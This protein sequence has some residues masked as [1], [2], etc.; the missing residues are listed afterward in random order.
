MPSTTIATSDHPVFKRFSRQQLVT[1]RRNI[2]YQTLVLQPTFPRAKRCKHCGRQFDSVW[3]EFQCHVCGLW[4]C[5]PCSYVLERERELQCITFMRSCVGCQPMLNKWLDPDL[6]AQFASSSW[7]VSCSKRQLSLNLSDILR[8]KECR[9]PALTVLKYL[10]RPVDPASP[11]VDT[12]TEDEWVAATSEGSVG[13]PRHGSIVSNNAEE[14]VVE[15]VQHLVQQCFEVVIPEEPISDC[16]FA[17]SNGSR[18]YPIHY[19]D[20][21]EPPDAPVIS[22]ELERQAAIARYGL[23]TRSLNTPEI[24]LICNLA[25]QELECWAA[26]I[27]IVSGDTQQFVASSPG[28][29]CGEPNKRSQT[30]CSYALTSP[31]PYMIRDASL[32]IRFRNFD[33][34][35]GPANLVFYVGFPIVDESNNTMALLCVLDKKPRKNIT[36][37]QYSVA[38]R[39]AAVVSALW[40]ELLVGMVKS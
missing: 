21:D 25:A 30:F 13:S 39:L 14:T 6:L 20:P 2:G 29:P 27:S 16:L 36:T 32:D 37:M 10:G 7:V 24:Q 18:L 33:V 17:E 4:V 9:R 5:Q 34:V 31:L 8:M 35:R 40:K 23:L 38:K 11:C 22:S 12:I 28:T 26:F 1:R 19:D 15:R 3:K